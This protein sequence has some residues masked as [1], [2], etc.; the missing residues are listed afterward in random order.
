MDTNA[1]VEKCLADGKEVFI[2]YFEKGATMMD[3]L[4]LQSA[5]E[6]HGLATTMWGIRQHP[7]KEHAER[8]D[9]HGALDLVIV[10]GV[11]FSTDGRRLGHGKGYY[12]R[13]LASHRQKYNS[14][15]VT[16]GVALKH[17]MVPDV[18]TTATDYLIDHVLYCS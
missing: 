15:P 4:R 18:P 14:A 7:D 9:Q 10:P 11:A 3:M 1:I 13:F 2:P 8:W 5:D 6:Y 17:Q 16:V 12:D